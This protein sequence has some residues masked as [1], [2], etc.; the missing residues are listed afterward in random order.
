MPVYQFL[1]E[2]HGEFESITIRAEWDQIRC[3]KCGGKTELSK[4]AGLD[5][6][7]YRKNR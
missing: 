4:E 7:R 5:R 3:P 2:K 6:K 1:C